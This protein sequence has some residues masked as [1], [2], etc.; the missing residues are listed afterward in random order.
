MPIII[1]S[2]LPLSSV[3]PPTSNLNLS[4]KP[5]KYK[6]GD[7]AYVV[8]AVNISDKDKKIC[9]GLGWIQEKKSK[10]GLFV[11]ISGKNRNEVINE[12]I[13]TLEHMKKLRKKDFGPVNYEIKEADCKQGYNCV[14]VIALYQIESWNLSEKQIDF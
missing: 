3:I 6:H 10:E 4:R 7:K 13:E 1:G 14:V 11:E 9:S 8:M 12:I 2:G 5:L